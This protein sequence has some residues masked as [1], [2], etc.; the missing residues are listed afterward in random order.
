VSADRPL[1]E[2]RDPVEARVADMFSALLGLDEPV[3]VDDDFL[4]LGADSLHLQELLADLERDFGR[5]LPATVLLSE[6]KVEQLADRLRGNGE[7][8][9]PPRVVTIQPHGTRPPLY[10][11]VRAGTLPTLHGLAPALG[12]EQ[13]ILGL[14]LPE[15]HASR[16]VATDER[17]LGEIAATAIAEHRPEGPYMLLG[18][19]SGGMVA[20]ETAQQLAAGGA[21]VELVVLLDTICRPRP[22]F[23]VTRRRLDRLFSRGGLHALARAA[24][25]RLGHTQADDVA[26]A[27]TAYVPGSTD[28]IQHRPSVEW[29]EG[30]WARRVPPAVGPVL[31][32]RT[33]EGQQ[34]TPEYESLGWD[35][36][37]DARWE[38]HDVPGGHH[39]ML[40]EPYVRAVAQRVA[41][42]L[43]RAST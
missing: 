11:I 5:R 1:V 40:G 28:M 9:D 12:R 37:I 10:C 26:A 13:P 4:A 2:P 15:M 3:S 41:D 19:S 27:S 24:N 22:T 33:R 20:Y 21:R 16:A 34:W 32:L 23:A 7:A 36:V 6:P 31:L 43:A 38:I 17:A 29:R 39:T 25:R 14:W 18:H 30:M 42:A 8:A 35:R